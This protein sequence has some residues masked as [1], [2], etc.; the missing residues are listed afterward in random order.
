[1][2]NQIGRRSV[3]LMVGIKDP[4]FETTA[5][6]NTKVRQPVSQNGA[7]NV[8][9]QHAAALQASAQLRRRV[10]VK[11]PAGETTPEANLRIRQP[12]NA[13][14]SDKPYSHRFADA[15]QAN[16]LRQWRQS[17]KD[18]AAEITAEANLRVRQP[19]NAT[20]GDKNYQQRFFVAIQ[21]NAALRRRNTR[22]DIPVEATYTRVR[23]PI[24]GIG[25]NRVRQLHALTVAEANRLL[26]RPAWRKDPAAEV[27][28][29]RNEQ[30][31]RPVNNG[32]V[33]A[34]ATRQRKNDSTC[35]ALA[36]TRLLTWRH[37]PGEPT[38]VTKVRTP[39]GA[40]QSN[41]T[42]LLRRQAAY[43][44]NLSLKA[45]MWPLRSEH[46]PVYIGEI[47][48]TLQDRGL[49]LTLLT[50][51]DFTVAPRLTDMTVLARGDLTLG[52]RTTVIKVWDR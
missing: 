10:P 29:V 24:N 6:Q 37:V 25:P 38:F 50:R 47:D 2:R 21:A 26:Q 18:P 52:S 7:R 48:L 44:A 8:A 40:A 3:S 23:Q 20:V 30:I 1:M 39:L 34:Q 11:D 28:A 13:T 49:S 46:D 19:I 32:S 33:A 22:P 35:S 17:R 14:A 41:R 4:A 51:G 27:T 15:I 5:V 9:V 16:A 36:L 42:G 12:V 45:I 43:A 31:R